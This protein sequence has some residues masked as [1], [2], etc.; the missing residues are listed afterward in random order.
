[1]LPYS[2]LCVFLTAYALILVPT[3][4]LACVWAECI[5]TPKNPAPGVTD[6]KQSSPADLLPPIIQQTINATTEAAEK[7]GKDTLTTSKTAAGDTVRTLEKAGKDTVTTIEK[8]K[9]DSVETVVKAADDAAATYR[10]AWR[11]VGSGGKKA[12][13]DVVGAGK[14]VARFAENQTKAHLNQFEAEKKRLADGKVVDSMWGTAVGPAQAGEENFAKATQE[15]DLLNQA[16]ASAAAVYGG[17]AGAAAYA[18]WSTYRRTGDAD[19]AFRAGIAAGLT[20]QYGGSTPSMPAN[21]TSEIVR[22]AALSGAAGGISVAAAGGDEQAITDG[23]LK[24]AGAVLIQAGRSKAEA[25]SPDLTDAA[26]TVQCISAQN[27]DCISNTTWARNAQGRILSDGNGQPRVAPQELDPNQ[28]VGKF[29]DIAQSAE[30]KKTAFMTEISKLPEMEA[31]PILDNQW[32]LTWDLSKGKNIL[33]KTPTVVLTNVGANPPFTS[34]VVYGKAVKAALVTPKV[35]PHSK[36]PDTSKQ[37]KPSQARPS[38]SPD[39]TA[40]GNRLQ[41]NG[42]DKHGWF[43]VE[44]NLKLTGGESGTV[45]RGAGGK[46]TVK[47]RTPYLFEP[48]RAFIIDANGTLS[49][50]GKNIGSCRIER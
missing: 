39:I 13:E 23:F 49:R 37:K 29:T 31:I 19:M 11:D 47:I 41:C 35:A 25:Y 38:P 42:H 17:P 7:L 32:V 8:A 15:S 36:K 33:H 43:Y 1:M 44:P 2:R 20:S 30:A 26:N 40:S 4:V 28:L 5:P 9:K 45:T 46:L 12:F 34:E 18:A 50:E 22:K 27:V 24:S 6:N 21:T 10:K 3:S 48:Q 16:A 14:A